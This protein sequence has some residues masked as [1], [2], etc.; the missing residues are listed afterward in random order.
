MHNLLI[1]ALS[2]SFG[3]FASNAVVG[4]ARPNLIVILA[5]D[6][7]Y[8]C[9]TANGGSSYETPNLDRLAASGVRYTNA[10][11]QPLCTPTRV[12]VMTGQY[13]VRNYVAFGLLKPGEV[14]F[15]NLLRDA[16]YHTAIAGK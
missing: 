2:L 11:V 12:Q 6:L 14:T 5:D 10:H 16:G 13:N 4:Q 8:E 9:L 3:V 1:A 7:G 15:G